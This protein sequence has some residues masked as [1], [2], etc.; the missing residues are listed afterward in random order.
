[1]QVKKSKNFIRHILILIGAVLFLIALTY[2][3]LKLFNKPSETDSKNNHLL[4]TEFLAL[5]EKKE[6]ASVEYRDDV[7]KFKAISKNGESF[8]VT[9]PEYPEFKKF[10]LET[11]IEVTHESTSFPSVLLRFFFELLFMILPIFILLYFIKGYLP[12]SKQPKQNRILNS[13]TKFSDVAGHRETKT[14]LILLV[15]FL[16]NPQK[17]KAL[18]AKLPKGV[19]L[20]GPPG[21]GKT[22]FAKAIAGEADVPF[23]HANASEFV[24]MYV[25]VGASRVRQLFKDAREKAPCVIFIDELEALAKKSFMDNSEKEQTLKQ[26]LVELDG[27]HEFSSVLVI[28]ATND[29]AALDETFTRSGRFD[30]HIAIGLPDVQDRLEIINHYA[31][32]KIFK[33][34]VD[35]D[36]LSKVTTSFSGADLSKLLNES[37][38]LASIKNKNAIDNQDLEEALYRS[39]MKGFEKKNLKRDPK[40]LEVVAYHEA[41]HAIVAKFL[42]KKHVPKVS[43]IASTSG[44]GGVTFIHHEKENLLSK[45]DLIDDIKIAYAGRAAEFIL[46]RDENQITTGSSS[47]IGLA[48]Q[49]LHAMVRS[50]GMS[51][52]GL[53]NLDAMQIKNETV[54]NELKSMA[55]AIYAETLAFLENHQALLVLLAKQLIEH[56]TLHEADLEKL[57]NAQEI[58]IQKSHLAS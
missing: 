5:V 22:L 31:K 27:F 46:F 9:N 50:F 19:I 8:Y 56:E 33:D 53:L 32:D 55:A 25:G 39:V 29:I 34:D 26:F 52:Y 18:G 2:S 28:G 36:H 49:K 3:M 12:K 16:R 57:W 48:T 7:S 38:I 11:G 13:N 54:L 41:G 20:Y 35:F 15:D 42:A 30:R 51:H 40:E 47:D 43:I 37:A 1:M 17:Y 24:E 45:Q 21:T 6:L 58:E 10:L 14:D 23:F 44:A 4:Y